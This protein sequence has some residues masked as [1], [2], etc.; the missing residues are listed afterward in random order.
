MKVIP[1]CINTT[2]K[3]NNTVEQN[4]YSLISSPRW[5]HATAACS[6]TVHNSAILCNW[7]REEDVWNRKPQS[8]DVW[9]NTRQTIYAIDNTIRLNQL[10]AELQ[11]NGHC[12]QTTYTIMYQQFHSRQTFS[13]LL[14]HYITHNTWSTPPP[15]KI[16][17]PSR[18]PKTTVWDRVSIQHEKY[19]YIHTH[20]TI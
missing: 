18:F 17:F 11:N 4:N 10:W 12:T 9:W 14:W 5:L 15:K 13:T 6:H 16:K 19:I 2:A 3:I 20:T 1:R 7:Q 8:L